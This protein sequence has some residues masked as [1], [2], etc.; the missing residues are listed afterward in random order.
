MT[1]RPAL[2]GQHCQEEIILPG[3]GGLHQI[4]LVRRGEH[5][6]EAIIETPHLGGWVRLDSMYLSR[7][8]VEGA[9]RLLGEEE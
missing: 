7:A 4:R 9:A 1:E 2:Y 5:M 6:V 8:V 3:E